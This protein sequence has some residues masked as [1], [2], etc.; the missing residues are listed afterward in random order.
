MHPAKIT[1][2]LS[3]YFTIISEITKKDVQEINDCLLT[4]LQMLERNKWDIDAYQGAQR[5]AVL[6]DSDC[7]HEEDHSLFAKFHS[8]YLKSIPELKLTDEDKI[9]KLVEEQKSTE[10]FKKEEDPIY[11]GK[12]NG[13]YT[14]GTLNSALLE[15]AYRIWSL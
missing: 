6:E 7:I 12:D 10:T 15:Q 1:K 3:R 9:K 14:T 5:M 4:N 2:E 13:D 8:A 11:H